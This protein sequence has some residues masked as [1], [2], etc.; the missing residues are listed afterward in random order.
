MYKVY[1]FASVAVGVKF[2]FD[3][4]YKRCKAYETDKKPQIEIEL[5][6]KDIEFEKATFL[7]ERNRSCTF[8]DGYLEYI[9]FYRKFV[10]KA[11]ERNVILFHGS[12][13]KYKD[14]AY[15]FV[16][17]SGTGK[18]T[19]VR[20]IKSIFNDEIICLN[21]DKPLIKIENDKVFVYGSAWD[22]KHRLSTNDYAELGAICCLNRGE[23]NSIHKLTEK[24]AVLGLLLQSYRPTDEKSSSKYFSLITKVLKY[25]VFKLYCNISKE[26]YTLSLLTMSKEYE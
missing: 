23:K 15:I 6:G 20:G 26:A 17:P 13:I 11:I 9:A 1:E 19:H 21:D 7:K 24:D 12:A 18:S 4:I 5:R 3:Y 25:P 8:T 14:R 22:G 16:A 2:N 10:I